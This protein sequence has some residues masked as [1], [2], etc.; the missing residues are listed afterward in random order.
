MITEVLGLGIQGQNI[1]L[2]TLKKVEEAKKKAAAFQGIDISGFSKKEAALISKL[3][4]IKAPTLAQELQSEVSKQESS[5]IDERNKR[6]SE[7][8]EPAMTAAQG[9]STLQT[10][11]AIKGL[12]AGSMSAINLASGGSLAP[13]ATAFSQGVSMFVDAAQSFVNQ[14]HGAAQINADTADAQ[15][16]AKNLLGGQGGNFARGQWLQERID[17]GTNTQRALIEGMGEKYGI[18]QDHLLRS[19]KDLFGSG[20]DSID[21]KQAQSIA[22]GNFSALGTDEGWFLDKISSQFSQ[23]PPTMR[24]ELTAGLIDSLDKSKLMKQGDIGEKTTMVRFENM[25][26]DTAASMASSADEAIKIQGL[27]NKGNSAMVAGMDKIVAELADL[28]AKI[29]AVKEK[30]DSIGAG[31]NT[32]SHIPGRPF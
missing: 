5:R 8:M 28:P 26:R 1:V 17:L 16:R 31:M 29:K 25:E 22:M 6:I 24:Q 13:F 27:L 18:I 3:S 11:A 30:L 19:T 2:S 10:G 32:L 21:A 14:V 12:V 7:H 23:L 9:L 15:N 4:S 20:K